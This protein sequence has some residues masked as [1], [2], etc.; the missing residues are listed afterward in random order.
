LVTCVFM[1]VYLALGSNLGDRHAYLQ[2]GVDGLSRR[3]VRVIRS[4]SLYSTEPHNMPSQPWFLNTVIKANTTL[5]AEQ[6]LGNCLAVEEEN[7]RKRTGKPESRTL[8]IDIIFYGDQTLKKSGLTIPHPEFRNRRFVLEPLA[9]I[10][11]DVVDPVTGKSIRQLLE[12][13]ND[14]A[15]VQIFG[16]PLREEIL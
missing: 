6:L 3:G 5:S 13:L 16:P 2:A 15:V 11:P 14:P 8:D 9:E 4:A 7:F 1:V 12:N 10:A